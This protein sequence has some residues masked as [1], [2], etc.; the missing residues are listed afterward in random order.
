MNYVFQN[1][2][3]KRLAQPTSNPESKRTE[4]EMS[5]YFNIEYFDKDESSY[6]HGLKLLLKAPDSLEW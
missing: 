4:M 2:K 6:K 3:F 5:S 1:I